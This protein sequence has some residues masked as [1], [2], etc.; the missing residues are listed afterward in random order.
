MVPF[1]LCK[2]FVEKMSIEDAKDSVDGDEG[3]DEQGDPNV[4]VVEE[5]DVTEIY[6]SMG[7]L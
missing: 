4:S 1:Y 3:H 5:G 2:V 6:L 7:K